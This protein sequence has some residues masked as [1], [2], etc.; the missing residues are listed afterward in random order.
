MKT[1]I[2][3]LDRGF[4]SYL[5]EGKMNLPNSYSNFEQ[6]FL[7]SS[8]WALHLIQQRIALDKNRKFN[9]KYGLTFDFNKYRFQN[10]NFHLLEEQNQVT[11][12]PSTVEIDKS[13]L[14]TT[15]LQIPMLLEFRTKPTK[16]LK[17]FKF[18][19]GGYAG[20]LIASKT[21]QK[22]EALGRVKVRDDFNLNRVRY[23]LTARTGMGPLNFYVNY[24]LNDLFDKE[25]NGGF[26]LRPITF[27]IS[28]LPF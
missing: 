24:A 23:G 21:K 7:G 11:F 13:S 27:G 22:S 4:S 6:R 25:E 8:H 28:I 19:V 5:H 26:E 12:I 9:F 20:I 18:G 17:V 14:S 3:L 16:G 2:L 1:R 10:E 15:H